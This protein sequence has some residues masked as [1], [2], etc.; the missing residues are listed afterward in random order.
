MIDHSGMDLASGSP[1]F[2]EADA[3]AYG[4][5]VH[6]YSLGEAAQFG[7]L[8]RAFRAE[9]AIAVVASDEV[10]ECKWF[11]FSAEFTM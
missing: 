3:L 11:H 5:F 7:E 4:A 1:H 8:A 6:L 9:Y 2:T 10:A